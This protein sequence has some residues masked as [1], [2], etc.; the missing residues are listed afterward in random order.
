[1]Q[2]FQ[3]QE[4]SGDFIQRKTNLKTNK[5]LVKSSLTERMN[6]RLVKFDD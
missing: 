4:L 1:M 5:V 6:N 2:C 3:E